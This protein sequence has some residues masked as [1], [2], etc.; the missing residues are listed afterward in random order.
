[1][2]LR[3]VVSL[4][5]LFHG[6][7]ELAYIVG[8][9]RTPAKPRK[10]GVYDCGGV[11]YLLCGRGSDISCSDRG[12]HHSVH[13]ILSA[14]IWCAFTSISPLAATVLLLGA[15]SLDPFRDTAYSGLRDPMRG[16]R[17]D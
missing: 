8:H 2:G 1:L 11:S 14:R 10:L 7:F 17:G 4:S 15:A 3:G 13:G 6:G 12:I 16:L 5:L 9:V